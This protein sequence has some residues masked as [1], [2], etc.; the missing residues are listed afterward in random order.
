[1]ETIDRLIVAQEGNITIEAPGISFTTKELIEISGIPLEV[2]AWSHSC[3]KA[4][5]ACGNCRGCN[6]Y[7]QVFEELGYALDRPPEPRP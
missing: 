5:L 7:F 1:V 4:T 2:L 6:K 3:H